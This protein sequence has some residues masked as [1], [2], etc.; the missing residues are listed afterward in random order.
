[1][2]E[3]PAVIWFRAE[4]DLAQRDLGQRVL[5]SSDGLVNLSIGVALGPELEGPGIPAGPPGRARSP[6]ELLRMW[7]FD[8]PRE[9]RRDLGR[10]L[11]EAA[12][13]TDSEALAR[14]LFEHFEAQ[15]RDSPWDNLERGTEVDARALD[16]LASAMREATPG[17]SRA[18]FL[19]EL[20]SGAAATLVS[21]REIDLIESLLPP[22]A[23]RFGPWKELEAALAHADLELLEPAAAAE[24]LRAVV[25]A[26][27]YDLDARMALGHALEMAGRPNDAASE[28]RRALEVQPGRRDVRRRL[29]MA[30]VRAGREEGSELV[31][32]LLKEDPEDEGLT[33]FRGPGP[34]PAPQVRFTIFANEHLGLEPTPDAGH[35]GHGH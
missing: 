16:L 3:T 1:M 24:H 27:P 30:L 8:R 31:E 34:Y 5:L 7:P 6:L 11:V 13:G 23:E 15:E 4:G 14:G 26:E 28:F 21:K 17:T 29:A 33:P 19:R 32:E 18:H 10:R 12:R 35:D 2:H 20:W 9:L 25:A 22:L